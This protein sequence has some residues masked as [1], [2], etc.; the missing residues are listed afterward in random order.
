VNRALYEDS[1]SSL[2]Q[3]GYKSFLPHAFCYSS[4]LLVDFLKEKKGSKGS[5]DGT[6][7][8]TS[9]SS[10]P[11]GVP[12]IQVSNEGMSLVGVSNVLIVSHLFIM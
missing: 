10:L 12:F 9:S 4:V 11:F 5:Q 3:E 1:W 6:M 8:N 7:P 2:D